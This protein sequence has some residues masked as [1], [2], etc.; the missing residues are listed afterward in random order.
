MM[1]TETNIRGL[2]TD[3]VA[4]LKYALEQYELALSRG[5][6]LRGFCWFPQVDSCG[7]DSLLARGAGRV[8]PVGVVSLTP[9]HEPVRTVFTDWWERAARGL[10]AADIPAYRWQEPCAT[11]LQGLSPATAHWRLED[12]P[13]AEIVPPQWVS[14]SVT[15]RS[16]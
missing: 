15:E 11:Q 13:V 5:V 14:R 7:W 6:D 2:P 1:L 9:G 16:N 12:P 8:D 4:W 10:P 3:R